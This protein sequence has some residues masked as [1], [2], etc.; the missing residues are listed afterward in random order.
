M[1]VCLAKKTT[2]EQKKYTQHSEKNN[3]IATEDEVEK[4]FNRKLLCI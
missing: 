1:N 4:T 2:I 3:N